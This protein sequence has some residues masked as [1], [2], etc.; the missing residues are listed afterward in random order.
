[1]MHTD[2]WHADR[3]T[4]T[5]IADRALD[6]SHYL[7]HARAF[8]N[9]RIHAPSPVHASGFQLWLM[10]RRLRS[11]CGIIKVTRPSVLQIPSRPQLTHSI[12]WIMLGWITVT[13]HIPQGDLT[14]IC[15]RLH[16]IVDKSKPSP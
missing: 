15:H 7:S 16:L 2:D 13:V 11:G 4:I 5:D 8:L 3:G 6:L 9:I 1:M 10:A 14:M 12:Q